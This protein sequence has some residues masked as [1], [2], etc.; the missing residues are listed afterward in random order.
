MGNVFSGGGRDM[1]LSN[2]ATGVFFDVLTLAGSAL[3]RTPWERRLVLYFAD[4]GRWGLGNAGFDLAELSWTD[5]WP[6]EKAF[7]DRMIALALTRHGWDRMDY[8][9]P[10]AARYLGDFREIV[11]GFTPVPVAAPGWGDWRVPPEPAFVAVCAVH[12]VFTGEYDCRFC[13]PGV[14]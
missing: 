8:D 3:A 10:H 13:S 4:G 2:G 6:A 7:L 9:P 12:G 5:D 1:Y 11:A 14:A